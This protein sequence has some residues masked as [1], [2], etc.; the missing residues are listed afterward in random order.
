MF[1]KLSAALLAMCLVTSCGGGGG[2]G[3]SS[4]GGGGGGNK[5]H[6]TPDRTSVEFAYDEGMSS[7]PTTSV[8]VTASGTYNGTL[9]IGAI[10]DGQGVDDSIVAS[11]SGMQAT[12]AI[13]PRSGLAAGTY[14]GHIQLMGCSDAACSKQIG[15]SP[16]SLA[17][18]LTVRA[19]LKATPAEVV[20]NAQSGSATSA[21]VTI[22]L[23]TGATSFSTAFASGE[24][25]MS[26]DQVSTTGFRVNLR[27]LPATTWNGSIRV[28]AGTSQINVPV[29]YTVAGGV[30]YSTMSVAPNGFTLTGIEGA[31]NA[32][33]TLSVTPSSWDPST[34]VRFMHVGTNDPV[35]WLSATPMAGGYA[36]VADATSLSAGTYDA[37]AVVSGGY[38]TQDV[39]VPIALTIGVGLVLPADQIKVINSESTAATLIGTAPVNVVTGPAVNW[40]AQSAAPWLILTDSAGATGETLAYRIDP[41]QLATLPNDGTEEWGGITVTPDRA[42]MSPR[43][44]AVRVSKRLAAI[45]H[46]G[47]YLQPTGRDTRV[48]LRGIG[49]DGVGNLAA[50]L[51]FSG[52]TVTQIT[53]VN[54]TELVV[55]TG[56]L[57]LGAFPFSFTNA[58]NATTAS[59][60]VKTFT[61]QTFAAASMPTGGDLRGMFYDAERSSV[62]LVNQ[63]LE[64]LQR[65]RFTNQWNL[66]SLAVPAIVS[67]GLTQDGSRVMVATS[68]STQGRIRQLD[69]ADMNVQ[70]TSTDLDQPIASDWNGD[71]QTTNDGRSWFAVGS[72]WNDMAY[73]DASAGTMTIVRPTLNTSFYA[74][75][76]FGMSRDGE[77]LMILQTGS[78]WQDMLYMDAAD[79]EVRVNPANLQNNYRM[80]F[81]DDASRYLNANYEVRD[82]DFALIGRLPNPLPRAAGDNQD[83]WVL[84]SVLSPDGSRVYAVAMPNDY[85]YQT[86][87]ARLYVFDSS[88]R[89]QA[90][91]ELPTLG[92]IDIAGYPACSPMP[93][94]TTCYSNSYITVSPDGNTVFVAGSSNLVVVPVGNPN[95][96]QVMRAP[97]SS[98]QKRG[99]GAT[100]PWHL[101]LQ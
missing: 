79:S 33:V 52:G 7:M 26:I 84:R 91:D 25:W 44:F 53:R 19:T 95:L 59:A 29:S 81:S 27:S 34:Q 17:Y 50:R 4:S 82:H 97:P 92:F 54:D 11:I 68:T 20:A 47:P 21:N 72:G 49:F 58:L 30:P 87:P 62:Y 3:G 28:S 36:V 93:P 23:P 39:Q 78:N 18:T 37:Q 24:E 77:R 63:N 15:N 90:S 86:T 2:G 60:A 76:G 71:I 43:T 75:P 40:T 31:V 64:S 35:S 56:P 61:P 5:I 55:N 65:F 69:A 70:I 6:F 14:T 98:A 89:Q 12:F 57:G 10:A 73:F 22:R 8:T 45:T 101:N 38:P 94:N 9:Y 48:I 85:P 32:P 66:T 67:A 80:S 99:R 42:S 41:A 74:G 16:V 100:V 83:H 51:H 46:V 13:Q 96:M 88:T 1:Q